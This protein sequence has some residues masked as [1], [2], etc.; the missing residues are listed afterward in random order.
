MLKRLLNIFSNRPDLSH[1]GRV[2]KKQ[3]RERDAAKPKHAMYARGRKLMEESM[4]RQAEL[5]RTTFDSMTDAVFILDAKLPVPTI[6]ECNKAASTIFGYEKN[7]MLGRNTAFL[8]MSEETL[9]EFQSLLYSAV[10]KDLLPFHL[11]D[12]RMKRKDGSIF[13]SEHSVSPLLNDKGERIGW[14]SI[15]RDITERKRSEEEARR[16]AQFLDL[17]IDSAN[18]WL[19]VL[20]EKGNVLIWNRAAEAISGYSRDQ[21][22]GHDK[23][24]GWLYP[25][26]KYRK[27]VTDKAA[28]IIQGGATDVEDETI[29]RTK[30]GENRIISWH[31]RNIVDSKGVPIGSVALGRDITER[32][33][34]EDALRESEEKYRALV[35]N[36]PDLIGIIQDGYLKYVNRTLCERL[37]WTFEEITSPSFNFIEKITAKQFRDFV[38]KNIED[39]LRGEAIPPYEITLLTRDGAEISVIVHAQ[40]IFY[41]GKPANEFSLVDITERK[42]TEE[43]IERLAK[44]HSENPNPVL[45]LSQDGIVL[46]ANKASDLLLRDWGCKVGG[47]APKFWHDLAAEALASQSSKSVDIEIGEQVYAFFV[48][49][50]KETDYV[51][52]YGRNITDRKRAE[53]K[54]KHYSEHLEELVEERTREIKMLNEG[55]VQRLIQKIGQIDNIAMI[56]DKLRRT[57]DI[58]TGLDLILDT[59]LT[60][61]GMDVGAVLL[62]DH[63][64]NAAKLRGFK[65]RME[66]IK[67]DESYRLDK[68]LAEFEAYKENK[69]LS[70]IVRQGEPSLLGTGSIHCAPILLGRDVYGVLTFGSQRDLILDN[71]DLAVLSL[72]AELASTLLETQSLVI[73]PVKEVAEGA[74]RRF[75]LESG[76]SYLVKNDVE[77][78]FEVFADNVLGGLEG[79]CI[80]REFPP[81]VRRKYGL[82]KTP[83]VWLTSERVEGETT[84]HSLQDLSILIASFLEKAQRGIVLLDGLEY[85]VT[86]HGFEISIRFLQ[87]SKSRFEQKDAILVAPLLEKALDTKEVTLI[88]R[89]MKPLIAQ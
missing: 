35:E 69:N 58:A 16:L 82:E 40:K 10:E 84:V 60:D 49:P 52:L 20:D 80:T 46:D 25:D 31:S 71:S 81:K 43:Q 73:A 9:R 51:N 15:V 57:P 3:R 13:Y 85:L 14:V 42:K 7:E 41:Q 59:A 53:E 32:K 56:R 89:E 26:E 37:G 50:V 47:V 34:M 70:R 64:E 30:K 76:G 88:E 79:L 39:R 86:N 33:R 4:H 18:V 83:I 54:L 62:I 67:L 63:K 5:L 66:G 68:A 27:E 55:I 8:H 6:L 48:A 23:I 21:V 36:S 38:K 29:I 44:F 11:A 22:I 74:K 65:S 12:H 19:D 28:L 72:Y 24:W 1:Y 78:A 61:L 2:G 17:V 75:E 45:R 77:K 87:T